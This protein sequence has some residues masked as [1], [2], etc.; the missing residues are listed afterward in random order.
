MT[1][2]E[3]LEKHRV[4]LFTKNERPLSQTQGGGHIKYDEL[5]TQS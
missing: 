2:V 5:P 1:K 4:V 3:L